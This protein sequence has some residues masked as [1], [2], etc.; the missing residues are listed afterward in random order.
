MAP[1]S[2]RRCTDVDV[3]VVGGGVVGASLALGLLKASYR[4]ALIDRK[5]P[6]S[7]QIERPD[8]RVYA[9]APDS[10]A[11]LEGLRIWPQVQRRRVQ[12]YRRMCVWDAG[13]ADD[14][15]FDAD[16]AGLDSLGSIVEHSLLVDRLW[17]SLSEHGQ[18]RLQIG[19][20]PAALEQDEHTAQL[21]LEDGTRISAALIIAAD[22]AD[23]ALRDMAGIGVDRHDYGQQGLVGY[24]DSEQPH[25]CTAWQRF[26]PS[27]PLALLPFVDAA[28]DTHARAAAQRR[29]SFVWSVDDAQ[30]QR[31][32]ALDDARFG[33]ELTRA[34]D[35][36]LGELTPRSPRAGFPLRRQLARS[37][38]AGRLL[39]AGDAAHS[40]HPLAGQGVN[41]GLRD[42]RL[43]LDLIGDATS[44][45]RDEQTD[46]GQQ[47][48][49]QR[50]ARERRSENAVAAWSFD[51]LNRL[52]STDA[53][54]P[55]VLR[56]PA[57][58][59]VGRIAPLQRLFMRRALGG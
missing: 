49:L 39:L 9:L 59:W 6:S 58:G 44:A 3:I 26:L 23:S 43:L 19:S 56:G 15:V 42:V 17:Q 35:A 54:L 20:P 25:Q 24:V 21:T 33:A 11:L 22:G 34:F 31:L 14:L 50:Y 37:Y 47:R 30:A 29:S 38:H 46:P 4:V 48:L 2:R 18:V 36:R 10:I 16:R 12:D 27:G 5:Q 53:I 41:L 1:S 57:L 45:A 51:G 52:F 7:W 28:G 40:V 13:G 8:L 32:L 55:T